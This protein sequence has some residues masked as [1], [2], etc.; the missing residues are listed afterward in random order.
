[1]DI[2]GAPRLC[3]DFRLQAMIRVTAPSSR[4]DPPRR[5]PLSHWTITAALVVP[6]VAA[7]IWFML[8]RHYGGQQA[9]IHL[10]AIRTH[11]DLSDR[12]RRDGRALLTARRQ[13]HTK[14]DPIWTH[15]AV[16]ADGSL[17]TITSEPQFGRL[18]PT[19]VKGV[20]LRSIA[21]RCTA[22]DRGYR[23]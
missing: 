4:P 7:V 20:D 10:D 22:I 16:S 5:D 2:E 15:R 11:C 18:R 19:V 21:S 13:R 3:D 14:A 9:P 6:T 17:T 1:M 12:H 23:G 8:L